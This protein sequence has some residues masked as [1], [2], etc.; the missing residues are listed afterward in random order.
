M[1]IV[2]VFSA[3]CAALIYLIISS[4]INY[5]SHIIIRMDWKMG[6]RVGVGDWDWD[7]D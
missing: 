3:H 6:M 5:H 7:W 1:K 4:H 2:L